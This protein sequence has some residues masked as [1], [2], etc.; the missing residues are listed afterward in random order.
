MRKQY[1]K[2]GRIYY[3][4]RD[5]NQY[6]RHE[7]DLD[8]VLHIC[9]DSH[10]LFQYSRF[11][12]QIRHIM[13]SFF[14][15]IIILTLLPA[16]SGCKNLV[17]WHKNDPKPQSGT[18]LTRDEDV[19]TFNDFRTIDSSM[20]EPAGPSKQNTS[21]LWDKSQARDIERRLGVVQGQ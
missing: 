8:T 20:M 1:G 15:M 6:F 2:L 16:L 12:M 7:T 18:I 3:D 5:S 9:D 4:N 21:L 10:S 13:R 19:M 11:T 14:A 17:W